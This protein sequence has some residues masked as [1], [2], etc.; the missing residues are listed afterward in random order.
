MTEQQFG[1]DSADS[2]NN[3]DSADSADVTHVM[4]V[5]DDMNPQEEIEQVDAADNVGGQEEQVVTVVF[6]ADNHL[7]YAASG[8]SPRKREEW[9]QRL[10]SAFQRATDFAVGQGVDLFIQAGDLF[11]SATP[12]ERD[13]SFVAARLAQLRQANVRVFALGGIHDTPLATHAN[14]SNAGDD[15]PAPQQSYASLGALTYFAPNTFELEPVM[16]DVHGTL[17]GVC[18]LSVLADQSGDP[19]ARMHVASD[20]ERAAIALLIL[21]APIAG[22]TSSSQLDSRTPLTQVS[23]E[24]IERQSAF[25]TILAGYHH[26]YQ[27]VPMGQREV[28]IAGATQHIDFAT[29][30]NADETP[31]FVFLG[32]DKNG[33]RWCKHI[34]V[35][36]PPLHKL[37]LRTEELW[38]SLSHATTAQQGATDAILARLLPL[39]DEQ[40]MVQLRLEG[41][42][43][44]QQYHQLDMNRLRRSGEEHTFAFALDDSGLELL[45]EDETKLSA[46]VGERFSP[47]EELITLA[48]EWIAAATDE[49]EK[50]AL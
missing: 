28:V 35:D 11:D 21:H 43:T 30:S 26:M 34:A 23:R 33:I 19:V 32:L 7:G 1:A 22:F 46:G 13:R 16:L 48:D 17:V 15:A 40:T 6:T 41:A 20:I 25:R 12:D 47:R 50:K 24:S 2:A 14:A 39:C 45:P 37:V 31:G 38:P 27:Q 42:L 18:G 3:V 8:Q 49:P 9:Q 10:R 5:V 36:A 44:R 4:D 29:P